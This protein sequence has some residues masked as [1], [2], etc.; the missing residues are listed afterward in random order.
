[1]NDDMVVVASVVIAKPFMLGLI[2]I[3]LTQVTSVM[4]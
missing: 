1:M 2:I 4:R 3:K